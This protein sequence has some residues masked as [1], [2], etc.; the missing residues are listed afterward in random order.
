M[1]ENLK[2]AKDQLEKKLKEM[3]SNPDE[4]VKNVDTIE[5]IVIILERINSLVNLTKK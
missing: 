3:T 2:S 1:T 4:L 5:R